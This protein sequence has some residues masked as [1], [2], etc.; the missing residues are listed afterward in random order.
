M[1]SFKTQYVLGIFKFQKWCDEDVLDFQ[2]L[3]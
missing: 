2:I 1:S 3:L